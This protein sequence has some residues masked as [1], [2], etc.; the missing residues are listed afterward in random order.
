MPGLYGYSGNA[1]VSVYNTTGLYNIGN[2]NIAL[3]GNVTV[4]NTTGLYQALGNPVILTSAQVLLTLLSNQGNVNFGL[5]PGNTQVFA[6]DLDS[7]FYGNAD[8]A[9]FLPTYTGSL[10]NSSS[11]IALVANAAV[12]SNQIVTVQ[13]NLNSF[14]TYANA[15]FGTSNF[16][17]SNVAIF[18]PTYTGNIS[19]SNYLYPNGVSIL[20]GIGGTYSNTNVAAYLPT[21]PTITSIQANVTAAN[22]AIQITNANLGAFQTYANATFSTSTY[23]NANVAAFLPTYTG[24]ISAGNI[25][26]TEQIQVPRIILT[27]T[28]VALGSDARVSATNGISIGPTAGSST[29]GQYSIAIGDGAG[30][31]LAQSAVAIGIGA[32]G[33]GSANGNFSIAI[34]ASAGT[35]SSANTIAIGRNTTR[36][37]TPGINS[38]AIGP[39]AGEYGMGANTIVINASNDQINSNT[40][41]AFY[42]NPIRNDSGNTSVALYYNTTSREVTYATASS[43]YS[44]TNVAAYLPTDPT[45]TAIQANVTA[46]NAAIQITNANLGA[47]QTYANA[48]FTNT[49]SNSNVAAYLPVY[50]GNITAG[51]ITISGTGQISTGNIVYTRSQMALGPGAKTNP[52]NGIA[53]GQNAGPATVSS[54]NGEFS[55]AIGEAA[56]RGLGRF[57]VAVG[58]NAGQALSGSQGNFSIA[59]GRYAAQKNIGANAIVIGSHAVIEGNS[60]T[61]SIALGT[62]AGAQG[63]GANTIIINATGS[64]L[65]GNTAGAL[66]IAPIRNDVGNVDIALY[67]NTTTREVTYATASSTYGNANVA[68]YLPT[69]PTFT[70]YL[71]FANANAATQA[72]A[73]NTINANVGAF[74]TYAN[75]TF[76]TST[77][78]NANVAEFLNNFGSNNI[79]TTGNISSNNLTVVNQE[80]AG[81]VRSTNGYFW[82]NGTIYGVTRIV[83]GANIVVS[84]AS[85]VGEV[86]ISSTAGGGT[87]QTSTGYYGSFFDN[88]NQYANVSTNSYTIQLNNTTGTNGVSLIN[89]NA[90]SFAYTGV[91]NVAFSIQLVNTDNAQHEVNVWVVQNGTILNDTNSQV[92]V[93]AR[94]NPSK[95]GAILMTVPFVLP[96]VANDIIQFAWQNDSGSSKVYIASFPAGTNPTRPSVPGV[97]A[98]A[99]QVTSVVNAYG[100]ANVAQFLNEFGSNSISTTGNITAGN[101]STTGNTQSAYFLGSA[102]K[103]TALT[104]ATAG[105]YGSDTTVPTIVVDTTG[106][107]TQITTNAIST[108][109]NANVAA[110][111][112]TDPTFTGY[113]TFANANAAT[114]ATAISTIDANLG[115]FEIYANATFSTSTYGNANVAAYLPTDPTFTGYLTFANANAA[116][117][118]TSIDTIN[119]NLG[120]YQI[121]ANANAATQATSINTINANLGA[122]QTYAN[123]TFSTSTFGNAN[124]AAFNQSTIFNPFLLAGM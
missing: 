37:I 22:A 76:S 3:Q 34:G 19:A 105:T 120:A 5:T 43:T 2:A 50:G 40:A 18:L 118:A 7:N 35:R 44:N 31:G 94:S 24:N 88:T 49:Y 12:Q 116:T 108:Y 73:I 84:P 20:T 52:S 65:N 72:T 70:G 61:N 101:V 106:R 28:S 25:T 15:T 60:G 21:D 112:P 114:Q 103:L 66:Y 8:V 41:G 80:I 30:K 59:I 78:G 92:T 23:G 104:G 64:Q 6:Y 102:E 68:A 36:A 63:I 16:G 48:T 1:N 87:G 51:N 119:A 81:N 4:S 39:G 11:I 82:G 58:P 27:S 93:P 107:I 74:Q 75:A 97:I 83:S 91:Y 56:G 57:T 122:F 113:L 10:D 47:F 121:Y 67:Y 98:L 62:S 29:Q 17:N 110:Y 95:P 86:T 38:I 71:T 42:V 77:Y 109:G 32:G 46:A 69:D 79:S 124:V 123:A 115:A 53:I 100:N 85:G 96:V 99:T 111:L 89:G 45:I 90:M 54:T 33:S 13:N 26:V 117:Q 14:G 9:A 55:V